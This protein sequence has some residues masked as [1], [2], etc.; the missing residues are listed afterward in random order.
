MAL[1]ACL[2]I[3]TPHLTLRGMN[4]STVIVDGTKPGSPPCSADAGDQN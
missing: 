3:A 4:R 2:L 1:L